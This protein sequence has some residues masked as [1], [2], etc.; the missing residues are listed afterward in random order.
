MNK[1]KKYSNE[2]LKTVTEHERKDKSQSK[3]EVL[4]GSMAPNLKEMKQLGKEM[5][6]MKTNQTLKKEGLVPDPIQDEEE[7]V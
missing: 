2:D 3:D 5:G 4:N 6:E 7:K 1:D